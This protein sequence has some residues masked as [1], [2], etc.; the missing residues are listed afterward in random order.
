MWSDF[1]QKG[2]ITFYWQMGGV[3]F[4]KIRYFLRAFVPINRIKGFFDVKNN[5][6]LLCMA[7]KNPLK[8]GICED[9]RLIPLFFELFLRKKIAAALIFTKLKP[10]AHIIF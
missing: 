3:D 5:I 1:S 7:C 4:G 9:I 10:S 8:K 6:V 2:K